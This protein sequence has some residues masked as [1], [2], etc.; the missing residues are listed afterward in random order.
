MKDLK[1]DITK[2][3][4]GLTPR[5]RLIVSAAAG[6]MVLFFIGNLIGGGISS[7][8]NTKSMAVKRQEDLNSISRLSQR[9]A[10]LNDKQKKVKASYQQAAMTFQ[11]VTV[12]LDSLIK[13]TLGTADFSLENTQEV[14]EAEKD[15]NRQEFK[16]VLRS[17]TLEQLVGILYRIENGPAPLFLGKVDLATSPAGNSLSATLSVYTI[18]KKDA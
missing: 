13:D 8:E 1:S 14:L 4:Q 15:F 9:Y 12:E 5:E 6:A 18:F 10:Q 7:L 11:Q 16:I 2:K 17:V 3:F